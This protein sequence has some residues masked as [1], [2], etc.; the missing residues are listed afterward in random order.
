MDTT[1][2]CDLTEYPIKITLATPT[3]LFKS[4]KTK[5]IETDKV[6]VIFKE[7]KQNDR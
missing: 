2:S 7:A 6:I 3:L 5:K 1:A 4:L